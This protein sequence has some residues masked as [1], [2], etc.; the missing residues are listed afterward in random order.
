MSS[1]FE[2]RSELIV[3]ISEQEDKEPILN[4]NFWVLD[5]LMFQIFLDLL[6]TLAKRNEALHKL[7]TTESPW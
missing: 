1:V 5:E 7:L 3:A 2:G 6:N 4:Q